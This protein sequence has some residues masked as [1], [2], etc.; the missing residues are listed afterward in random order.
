MSDQPDIVSELAGLMNRN[1]GAESFM[2]DRAMVENHQLRADNA[3]LAAEVRAWRVLFSPASKGG[4][5]FFRNRKNADEAQAKTDASGAL[6]RN[7]GD[8]Q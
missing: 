3:V 5:N 8:T 1:T 6:E 7:A 2:R 4:G